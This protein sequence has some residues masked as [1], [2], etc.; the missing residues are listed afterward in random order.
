[1]YPHD[2]YKQQQIAAMSR[3]DLI[4]TLYRKALDLLQRA[5]Q[6]LTEDRADDA[7]PH[8]A[9]AQLIVTSL[10]S[11]L[12]GSTDEV[13]V[14]FLRLYEF[15]TDRLARETVGDVEAAQ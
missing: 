10:A 7:R 15:V 11:G 13:A 8:L 5:H 4:L 6:A 2:A 14:N 12:A 3:I 1:M 9:Q